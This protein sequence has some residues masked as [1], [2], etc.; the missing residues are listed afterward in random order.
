MKRNG[1]RL[2]HLKDNIIYQYLN[3]K[4]PRKK[5]ESNGLTTYSR[6]NSYKKTFLTWERKQ[7]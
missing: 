7:S 2:R 3:G 6:H 1:D 5:S 4:G